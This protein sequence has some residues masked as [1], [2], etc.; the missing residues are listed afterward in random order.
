M[1][2]SYYIVALLCIQKQIKQIYSPRKDGIRQHDYKHYG[3]YLSLFF[4]FICFNIFRFLEQLSGLKII[5]FA[6]R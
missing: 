5:G 4:N 3:F 6:W 2:A 1:I